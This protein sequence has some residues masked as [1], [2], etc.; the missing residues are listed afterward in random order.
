MGK[1]RE[2]ASDY[3][4][5]ENQLLEL[6]V[7]VQRSLQALRP[8][9]DRDDVQL[10]IGDPRRVTKVLAEWLVR[11]PARSVATVR[12]R[13]DYETSREESFFHAGIT[14]LKQA[15]LMDCFKPWNDKT[16]RVLEMSLV[17]IDRDLTR[18]IC[19][20]LGYPGFRTATLEE[21]LAYLKQCSPLESVM[22]DR[23]ER[24]LPCQSKRVVHLFGSVV[25]IC[26]F[27]GRQAYPVIIDTE[28]TGAPGNRG[29][30]VLRWERTLEDRPFPWEIGNLKEW[31]N[32]WDNHVL[33]VREEQPQ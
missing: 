9:L 19:E 10:L 1:T 4:V 33:I 12:V 5:S 30:G 2:Q 18:N 8:K 22:R 15:R 17:K 32:G 23:G 28:W 27:S 24:G 16:D 26:S 7:A 14:R 13:V 20:S 29:N 3:T 25:H 21:A 6:S 31:L 11:P